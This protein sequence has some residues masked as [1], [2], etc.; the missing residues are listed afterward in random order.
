MCHSQLRACAAER[1]KL[2][3][4][5]FAVIFRR[6]RFIDHSY[7]WRKTA[8]IYPHAVGALIPYQP[9]AAAHNPLEH[10]SPSP[11]FLWKSWMWTILHGLSLLHPRFLEHFPAKLPC[12]YSN[13]EFSPHGTTATTAF[14]ACGI[15]MRNMW[16]RRGKTGKTPPPGSRGKR[17]DRRLLPP[18]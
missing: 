7:W 5:I 17:R 15:I 9:R 11:P 18:H 10:A 13:P 6:P 1:Q 8:K 16:T 12:I 3:K 14:H 4:I 2:G